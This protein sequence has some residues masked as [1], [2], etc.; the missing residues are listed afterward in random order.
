M[1]LAIRD[2]DIPLSLQNKQKLACSFL[3]IVLKWGLRRKISLL[4]FCALI[5]SGYKMKHRQH[6]VSNLLYVCNLCLS[7]SLC[8]YC[9]YLLHLIAPLKI[10][11]QIKPGHWVIEN[12]VWYLKSAFLT[13]QKDSVGVYLY[14]GL[15]FQGNKIIL[16]TETEWTK[17]ITVI[18]E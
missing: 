16:K 13:R 17:I 8:C 14:F 10:R 2:L 15:L 3:C 11:F 7:L 18:N 9:E 4:L 6:G 1:R 5:C 12:H